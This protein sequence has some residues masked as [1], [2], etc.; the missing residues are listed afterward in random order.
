MKRSEIRRTLRLASRGSTAAFRR[1]AE[2]YVD[3]V[4]EAVTLANAGTVQSITNRSQGVFHGMWREIGVMRRVSDVECFLA[5][6]IQRIES[7]GEGTG[8]G[9][10]LLGRLMGLEAPDR[11]L[12]V[13]RDM[14]GWELKRVSRALRIDPKDIDYR[15]CRARCALVGFGQ[16]TDREEAQRILEISRRITEGNCCRHCIPKENGTRLREFRDSW[17]E[18]RTELIELRQDMRFDGPEREWFLDGLKSWAEQGAPERLGPIPMIRN[19]FRFEPQL[20]IRD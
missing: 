4:T 3:L 9:S 15:I 12:V 6:A 8:L 13:L 20:M 5:M 14:E 11:T 7:L 19:F 17:M 2:P 1:L 16:P 18:A 10:H